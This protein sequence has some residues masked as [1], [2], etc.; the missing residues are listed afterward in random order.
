[1]N[2]LNASNLALVSFGQEFNAHSGII[3]DNLFW[4]RL[5]RVR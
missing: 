4:F 5:C 3:T 1:M 2:I